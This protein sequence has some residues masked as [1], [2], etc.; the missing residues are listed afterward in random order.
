MTPFNQKLTKHILLIGIVCSLFSCS[1]SK[2]S[3][4]W[5]EPDNT[6]TYD[7][8]LIIGIGES[9]QDRRA[10]ESHFVN[11]L[12]AIGTE[13]EAS[14]KLIKNGQEIERDTIKKAIKGKEINGVIITR[15]VAVDEETIYRPPPAYIGYDELYD[16]YPIAY[17]YVHSPGYYTTHDI[18]ILETNLYDV[19]SE[20][21]VWSAR[22]R[23][24]S[25]SSADEVIVDLTK[26]LI[27]DLQEKG[28][29]K[30]KYNYLSG[31]SLN[32]MS[33]IIMAWS[34]NMSGNT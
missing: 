17:A 22:S 11:E 4:S 31:L 32:R 21:L 18:Y 9:E 16:Y 34:D 12:R 3:Q 14:Y 20:D 29:I 2:I 8:L 23:T 7:D 30:N 10:Y 26:L 33:A 28:L 24:F 27:K 25:P 13:A 5:V 19:V 15:I 6:R 1:S